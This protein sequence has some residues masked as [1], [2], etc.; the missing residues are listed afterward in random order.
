MLYPKPSN[1]RS[2]M[3]NLGI[4]LVFLIYGF[5]VLVSALVNAVGGTAFNSLPTLVMD[6]DI[7][8]R[9]CRYSKAYSMLQVNCS[10]LEWSEISPNLRTDIQ[11]LDASVNRLRDLNSESLSR[12]KSLAYLY[13]ADNFIQN[14]DEYGLKQL[15]YLQV[16]DLTKNGCDDLPPVL[17][18]LPYLRKLYLAH[19]KL[20]DSILNVET[21]SPLT[22]MDLSKNKLTKIP[23]MSP[24]PTLQHLNLSGN[25]IVS[26]TEKELA[27]FCN[28]KTLDLTKNPIKFNDDNC[29]CQTFNT[30]IRERNIRLMPN[31]TCNN[32]APQCN[33]VKFSNSTVTV[34][35]ECENVLRVKAEVEQARS[36]WILVACCVSGFLLLNFIILYC[37]HKRNRRNKKKRQKEKEEQ[38]LTVNNA[39]TDLLNSNLTPE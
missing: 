36:M 37:V 34:Y 3:N 5:L 21:K 13:L 38:S 15:H 6:Q 27:F 12:Y 22:F 30:W 1:N 7:P 19:N 9:R 20:T 35:Q 23:E 29:E 26:V 17:F 28:L 18:Q 4:S 32:A 2:A 31:I 14:I 10:N 16:L 33:L 24:I 8:M 25:H 39:N 11:I